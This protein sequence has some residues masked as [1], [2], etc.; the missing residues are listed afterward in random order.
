MAFKATF[1]P[2][3]KKLTASLGVQEGKIIFFLVFYKE[4][5]SEQRDYVGY[6]KSQGRKVADPGIKPLMT[7]AVTERGCQADK[8]SNAHFHLP[9]CLKHA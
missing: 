8:W 6:P 7:H 2:D 3:L 1:T 4:G 9:T 5:V